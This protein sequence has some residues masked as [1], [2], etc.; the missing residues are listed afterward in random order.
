[1]TPLTKDELG[2]FRTLLE[3]R[4][5]QAVQRTAQE[6]QLQ[7]E[8]EPRPDQLNDVGDRAVQDVET[9]AALTHT[10]RNNHE[11]SEV[12]MALLRL[13]RGEYGLCEAC[14]EPIDR[15]RLEVLPE[16]RTCAP[17]ARAAEAGQPRHPTL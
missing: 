6:L 10:R 8:L 1:M 4:R 11:R 3:Q 2:H 14:G 12:E 17:C 7:A 9:D 16:A 5:D 15:R 13:D